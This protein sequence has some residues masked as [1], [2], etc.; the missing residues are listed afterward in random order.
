MLPTGEPA[1][2]TQPGGLDAELKHLLW[3]TNLTVQA[4]LAIPHASGFS[5][6]IDRANQNVFEDKL[7]MSK[8]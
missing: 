8:I 4:R 1:S 6:A 2:L 7:R 5:L 3:E